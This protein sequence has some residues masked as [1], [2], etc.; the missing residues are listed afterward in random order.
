MNIRTR[1]FRGLV[2]LFA[3]I[4]VLSVTTSLI[5]EYYRSPLDE[6]TGSISQGLE[7]NEDYGEW[8]YGTQ[9]TSTKDAVDSMKE[10]AIREAAESFVLLKNENNSLPLKQEK[11]KVT[12]FGIRSFTPYY[13]STTGGSIP[14]KAVIDN[15]P[16]RST[17]ITDF[18]EAFDVNPALLEAYRDYTSDYTWGSSGFGAQAPAYQGLYS[19]TD[20]TEPTLSELGITDSNARYREYNDAAIVI[21][22]RV[23]G[24]GSSFFPG[25]E[26]RTTRD[27][28]DPTKILNVVETDT[29]NILG[30][31]EEEQALIDTAAANFDNVIVLI[32]SSSQ[33]EIES[34]KQNEDVD[35][36]MWI[37]YPGVYGFEAVAQVLKG[38]ANP[39]GRLGDI[40]AVNSALSPAMQNYGGSEVGTEIAWTNAS[41]YSGMNVNS[42]LVE[43][44]GIY[45]G[46]RYY[47]TRYADSLLADDARNAASAK[48]GTYVNYNKE[49]LTFKPATTDGQW[50]Y[51]NEV[52]YPFGYGLSYT[53]FTQT[54]TS[55]EVSADHKTATATVT[56]TNNGSVAGKSVV[57][58]YAQLPYE[59]GDVEK[60]AIQLIDYEKTDLLASGA[61]E[62]VILNIDMSNL[63]SYDYEGAKTYRM[64]AGTY[65]FAIGE[66]SHDALNNIL[67]EQ[68]VSGMVNTDGT[69]YAAPQEN[70]VDE[71]TLAEDDTTTFAVSDTTNKEI[72]NQITEGDYA[73]DV[74][75]WL[76]NGID[77]DIDEVIYLSRSDW[78]NTFPITYSNFAIQS[79]SRFEEIMKNDFI[80]LASG[81]DISGITMGDSSVELNF[82]DMKDV[83]FEDD[84]WDELISKIPLSEMM[85]FMQ[86][87]FHQ[88]YQ[89]PSIGFN[90]FNADDGPG[91]SDSHDMG[92]AS[93]QGTLFEDAKDYA[94]KVGTRIAPAPIN[95]AYTFNKELAYE[96]G[97]ILLG[98]STL[99]Y[100]LPIMIGPGMNI[101]RT[102]Y[103]GRNVE[104][105]SEDP[106]LSGFTGSAV[107]QGAQSKGCLVNIK[108]VG[109]NSQEANR[110][111]VNEFLN[112]QAA[113][114]LELRNLQQ[115][116]T[117]KGRSSK[118]EAEGTTF[119]YAAEG[120]R[121]TM[122]AYNRIGA[123]ASSANYG[124]QYA[125]LREEWGFK[126][127]SVTD[128]TGLNP[129]AAPKESIF[130]GT[131]AFCGFGSSTSYWTETAL[132]GDA[133]LLKAM[134]NSMHY[135]LYAL[136]RSY[137]MDLVN[138]HT[139]SLM[140]WW[141]AMYISLI[142]ISS[143]LTAASAAAYV[144]LSIRDKKSVKEA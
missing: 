66:S 53:N 121:G 73:T 56:V 111:G 72:T 136:S 42:Y 100:N 135:A 55:V 96:N 83:A 133:D 88:I 11:P 64:D 68:G 9:Y 143:V 78:N 43:A 69:A 54:L 80:P 105:Y 75:Y 16:N 28:N 45:T 25:Q 10:F 79:G 131:T 102:P 124:V 132:S 50:V 93:N 20:P 60:S 120:A 109:F 5:M 140:T 125:I 98:E 99:L 29:D 32:N 115:A 117:A 92:E 107:V 74:N 65:Y 41:S 35:A 61:S 34:L 44:E 130:A 6:N 141:R 4:L 59:D 138:T 13:G 116:F 81:E 108:H 27:S 46:Y 114:E 38:E 126:G 112:E 26:G 67:A 119:R 71:W 17:L 1:L 123:T 63:A 14:D 85:G 97:E 129:I 90:G 106:I 139:V 49:E 103:N 52:S 57:Q 51:S 31:S 2:L 21:I 101:H 18:Q 30:I 82:S 33:M 3:F 8:T 23:S 40:Y 142:T 76:K 12:L 110:S 95:L 47:E 84:R 37:G 22:G 91:G 87:A 127:Y 122:T 15:D 77:A 24:E 39:S 62:T 48:A 58:L 128:F 118:S 7:V 19:T 134:Q 137:A 86:N 113:R 104:Y 36:V 89:I 70:K 94:G 144:V